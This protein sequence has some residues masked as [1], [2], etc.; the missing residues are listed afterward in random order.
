MNHPEIFVL[1]HNSFNTYLVLF[2]SDLNKAQIYEM[3]C[4]VSSNDEIEILMSFIYL[5][6][7]KPNKRTQDYHSRNQAMTICYS[8][9][10][11]KKVFMW[12]KK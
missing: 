7:F 10:K 1:T 8:N 6:A 11:M 9:L 12:E 4:K 5:N 3:P 2:F